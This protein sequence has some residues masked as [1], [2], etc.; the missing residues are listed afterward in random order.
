M[1]DISAHGVALDF[2][3]VCCDRRRCYSLTGEWS[4]EG[5]ELG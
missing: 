4:E 2:L 1:A 5:A 3:H